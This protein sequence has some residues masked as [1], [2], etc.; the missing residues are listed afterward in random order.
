MPLKVRQ[1]E[2]EKNATL[3]DL[4]GEQCEPQGA[5]EGGCTVS[6]SSGKVPDTRLAEAAS[7]SVCSSD[8]GGDP[9]SWPCAAFDR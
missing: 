1:V 2:A 6:K 4:A 3:L 8:F 7:E 5:F 9:Q